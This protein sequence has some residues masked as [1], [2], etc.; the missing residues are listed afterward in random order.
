[1]RRSRPIE[2]SKQ[3]EHLEKKHVLLKARVRELDERIHLTANEQRER[4]Q[5]K[6]E[7]LLTKDA[8][9]GLTSEPV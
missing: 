1:M 5:L 7:K 2:L 8:L 3:V 4:V 6:K 9:A